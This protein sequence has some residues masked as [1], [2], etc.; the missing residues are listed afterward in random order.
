MKHFLI[1][2]LWASILSL[3]PGQD[4][5]FPEAETKGA[6]LGKAALHSSQP[7][8]ALDDLKQ[9]VATLTSAAFEGRLTGA[10]GE[11][12][13]T[14]YF[15][16]FLEELGI[17][18]A[19]KDGTFYD[20]FQFRVGKIYQ[21]KNSLTLV[22]TDEGKR[23]FTP[24]PDYHALSISAAKVV[25]LT[26][27]VFAGFGIDA[28]GYNSFQDLEIEG[29]W[30]LLLRGAPQ[31]R[32]DLRPYQS[33]FRKAEEAKKKGASGILFIKASHP[34]TA[35]ELIPPDISVGPAKEI[36]PAFTISDELAASLLQSREEGETDLTALFAT[37]HGEEEVRGFPLPLQAEA[38]IGLGTKY[39]PGRNVLGRLVVGERPSEQTIIIGGHIDHLGF[40][41]RGGSLAK[42]EAATQLHPG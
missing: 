15:A 7:E 24:G 12:M 22:T 30:L 34:N 11:A 25:E 21:G 39:L 36:L 16:Q 42:G 1:P 26:D 33:L 38:S 41:E 3:L 14:A 13:A 6:N 8:I 31:G 28:K 35:A 27:I 10:K 2:L 29:K 18:P 23:N 40:G 19:G 4:E 20:P 17:A 37:Y 5:R 32:S 9:Y